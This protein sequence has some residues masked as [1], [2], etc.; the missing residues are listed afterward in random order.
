MK[1]KFRKYDIRQL[2]E[3]ID[4]T[5]RKR[6]TLTYEW[7]NGKRFYKNELPSVSLPPTPP[8]PET[9]KQFITSAGENFITSDVQ[10]F[11]VL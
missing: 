5:V 2:I 8:T 3:K 7:S 11:K 10:N 1:T 4:P 9:S 6:L